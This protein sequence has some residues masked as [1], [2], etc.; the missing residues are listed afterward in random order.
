[1]LSVVPLLEILEEISENVESIKTVSR[2]ML[3][4]KILELQNKE[5]GEFE[6]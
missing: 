3:K 2:P 4:V 1:M 6:K 5:I